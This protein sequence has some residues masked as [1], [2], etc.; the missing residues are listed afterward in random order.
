[1]RVAL[2]GGGEVRRRPRSASSSRSR[3][4]RHAVEF[5]NLLPGMPRSGGPVAAA[6]RPEV[7]VGVV[8]DRVELRLVA[9]GLVDDVSRA[10]HRGP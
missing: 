9:R 3:G 1:M 10:D 2:A 6:L 5:K 8:R 7:R 4:W